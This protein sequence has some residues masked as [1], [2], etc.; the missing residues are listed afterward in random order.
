MGNRGNYLEEICN[1]IG[2][3]SIEDDLSS[4]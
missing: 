3:K 4:N 2:V 1:A